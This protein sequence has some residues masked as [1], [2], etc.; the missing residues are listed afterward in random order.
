ME[1]ERE[2][3]LVSGEENEMG[4]GARSWRRR[5]FSARSIGAMKTSESKS[6][7]DFAGKSG[8]NGDDGF[9]VRFWP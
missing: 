2:A 3:A 1:C 8:D 4:E 5:G 6:I 7:C 9:S